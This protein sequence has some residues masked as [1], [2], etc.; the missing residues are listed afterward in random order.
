MA[1]FS[2]T[3]II[4]RIAAYIPRLSNGLR[5][6]AVYLKS[7][8]VAGAA[9]GHANKIGTALEYAALGLDKAGG[10]VNG[11]GAKRITDAANSFDYALSLTG[12]AAL[13]KVNDMFSLSANAATAVQPAIEGKSVKAA[14]VSVIND[15]SN[16]TTP[17]DHSRKTT[18]DLPQSR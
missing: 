16:L 8:S 4:P 17:I 10:M 11:D 5:T 1:G 7:Q 2:P 3:E 9:D 14:W 18:F 13:K 15:V 6:A 12:Q